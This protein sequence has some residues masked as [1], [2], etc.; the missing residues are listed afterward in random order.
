LDKTVIGLV[1]AASA[2]A[3]AGGAQAARAP[4]DEVTLRPA[5]SYAELLDPIPGAVEKL[6]AQSESTAANEE[7]P[8]QLAQVPV[9]VPVPGYGYHH[10]H[11]HHGW[12]RWQYYPSHHHHHHHHHHHYDQG[13]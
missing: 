5:Q 9:P 13:Y 1:G 4:A 2:L 12:Y 10:H 7:S 11:H 6:R 8:L 3:L